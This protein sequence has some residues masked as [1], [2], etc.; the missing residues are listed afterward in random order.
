MSDDPRLDEALSRLDQLERARAA[1]G[2]PT[3]EGNTVGTGRPTRPAGHNSPGM[4]VARNP[5]NARAL[6]KLEELPRTGDGGFDQQSVAEAFDAFRRNAMQM[7]AELRVVRAAGG[8]APA[9]V[10]QAPATPA[11]GGHEARLSAMRIIRAAAEFAD[12]IEREAQRTAAAQLSRVGHPEQYLREAQKEASEI[13]AKARQEADEVMSH[14]RRN[15]DGMSANVQ[16]EVDETLSWARAQAG[17]I[18]ERVQEVAQ[19][20]LSAASLGPNRADEVAEAIVRA[21]H[22]STVA[23]SGP[24]PSLIAPLYKS[25]GSAREDAAGSPEPGDRPA[26]EP[27]DTTR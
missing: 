13:V 22:A 18:L 15:A 16:S 17:S 20:L 21:A 26:P 19:Q 25:L 8:R 3:I 11:V 10:R 23:T 6:P 27:D 4:S 12:A 1:E 14:A 2:P 7:S 9:V 5:S 24:P